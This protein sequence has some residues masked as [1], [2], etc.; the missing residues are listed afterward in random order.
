MLITGATGLV[1]SAITQAFYTH[2]FDVTATCYGPALDIPVKWVDFDFF[3]LEES[4]AK[5]NTL[6]RFDVLVHNAGVV[7]SGATTAQYNE[8]ISVNILFT[9]ALFNWA[10]NNI[11][12]C[13]VYTSSLSFLQRPLPKLVTEDASVNATDVYSFSKYSGEKYLALPEFTKL[14]KIIFRLASP[15]ANELSLM[16]NTV[17]KKWMNSARNDKKITVFGKGTRRQNFVATA[18][19]ASAMVQAVNSPNASGVYNIASTINL[20]MA[21]LA[22]LIAGKFNATVE[23]AGDDALAQEQWNISFEKATA[24][25]GYAPVFDSLTSVSQLLNSAL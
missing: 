5:L 8:V 10:A 7:K 1:G 19:I 23:Y 13:I 15:V 17:L 12:N 4:I 22:T 2:G 16:P 25:F 11:S 14:R 20:S 3:N 6:G 18:D 24:D 9:N 21:E